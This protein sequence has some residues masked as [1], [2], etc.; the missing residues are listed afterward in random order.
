MNKKEEYNPYNDDTLHSTQHENL[1]QTIDERKG[2]ND[3]IKHYDL[4]NGH[5]SPKR[6]EHFPRKLRSVL[7]III[8]VGIA[9]FIVFQIY[10]LINLF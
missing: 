3:V 10:S 9:T 8:I 5:Q 6:L 7:K 2:F 1:L 4:I